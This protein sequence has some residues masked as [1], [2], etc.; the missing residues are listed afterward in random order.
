M[1]DKEHV[2]ND[3]IEAMKMMRERRMTREREKE[4]EDEAVRQ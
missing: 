1:R 4:A 2:R 3:E